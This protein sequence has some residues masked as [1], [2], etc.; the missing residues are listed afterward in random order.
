MVTATAGGRRADLPCVG[1]HRWLLT[2]SLLWP[3]QN[4]FD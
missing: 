2:R 4:A 1:F 3:K